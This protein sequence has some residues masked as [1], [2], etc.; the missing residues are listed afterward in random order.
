LRCVHA[1]FKQDDTDLKS[2]NLKDGHTFMMMGTASGEGL[3]KPAEKPQFLEDMS[4]SE[5]NV[6][7]RSSSSALIL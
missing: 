4:E 7:V 6:V 5:V 2:L 1:A 3:K